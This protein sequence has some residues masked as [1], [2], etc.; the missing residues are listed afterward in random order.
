MNKK[1][2]LL[3]LCFI[4]SCSPPVGT[5]PAEYLNLPTYW[6]EVVN[7]LNENNPKALKRS[8]LNGQKQEK[9]I[10]GLDWNKELEAFAAIDLNI[11]AN[12]GSFDTHQSGD[13]TRY[14]LKKGF[15]KDIKEVLVVIKDQKLQFFKANISTSNALYSYKRALKAEIINGQLK[16]YSFEG[17]Q[18]LLVGEKET[19]TIEGTIL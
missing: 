4:V 6:T 14:S 9:T 12:R 3:L 10:Q 8:I 1:V 16:T 7:Q 2:A 13:T 11:T 15:E 19:F 5:G 17:S 18:E